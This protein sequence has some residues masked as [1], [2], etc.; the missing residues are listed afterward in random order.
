MKKVYIVRFVNPNWGKECG[1]DTG[2]VYSTKR[3]AQA[4]RN[5]LQSLGFINVCIKQRRT[6]MYYLNS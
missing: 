3:K 5:E 1:Y 4:R 6:D 2:G